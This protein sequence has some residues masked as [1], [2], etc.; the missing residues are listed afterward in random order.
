[1]FV[2]S[3]GWGTLDVF[4]APM[5]MCGLAVRNGK[6]SPNQE[7]GLQNRGRLKVLNVTKLILND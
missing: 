7:T 6:K 2:Q 4:H 5:S 3:G 1:M